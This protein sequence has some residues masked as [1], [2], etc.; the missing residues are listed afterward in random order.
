MNEEEEDDNPLTLFL[1]MLNAPE[2]K[3]QYPKRLQVF[4][5][6]LGFI[7]DIES[8]SRTFVAKFKKDDDNNRSLQKQLIGFAGHQE[9]R[10]AN[11]ELSASTSPNYFKAIKL[12]C[13]SNNLENRVNW[14]VVSK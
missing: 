7:G 3:R 10:V 11:K 4:F 13:Q 9:E 6:F 12:F 1:A 14:K 5:N 2:S 8:Q